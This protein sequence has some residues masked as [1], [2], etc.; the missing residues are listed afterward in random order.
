M[1]PHDS[2]ENLSKLLIEKRDKECNCGNYKEEKEGMSGP[3]LNKK[4]V[5]KEDNIDTIFKKSESVELI[6]EKL[7]R[8]E[9]AQ[10][11]SNK[12][13]TSFQKPTISSECKKEGL[14]DYFLFW[15]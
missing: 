2:N 5:E 6:L 11:E 12:K 15:S 13:D 3:N 1:A 9:K 7:D 4:N 10:T 8:I 14:E